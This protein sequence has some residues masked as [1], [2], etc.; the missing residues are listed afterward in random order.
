MRSIGAI[1]WNDLLSS[2]ERLKAMKSD[3]LNPEGER[4]PA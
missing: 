1:G 3:Q 2:A 4:R